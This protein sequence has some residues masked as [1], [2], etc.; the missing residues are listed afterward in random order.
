MANHP[1][2]QAAREINDYA[3]HHGIA[4]TVEHY[5]LKTEDVRYIADQRALR[6]VYAF[7]GVNLNIT[8]PVVLSLSPG[9]K[10]LH[11]QLASAY[12][13]ALMIGWRA[14]EISDE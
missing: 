9:E 12:M 6:A 5:G 7:K 13:D 1:L 11:L 4:E 8:E 14:K 3:D 2:A 10:A